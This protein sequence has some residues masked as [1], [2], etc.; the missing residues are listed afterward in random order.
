MQARLV[1]VPHSPWSEKA[2][3]ALDHHGIDYVL[4]PYQPILGE[5]ALRLKLKKRSGKVTVPVLL[6]ERGPVTDSFDIAMFA[7]RHGHGA[8]LFR[9]GDKP[10]IDHWN[11]VSERAM[12]AGRGLHLH[13]VRADPEALREALPG[14]FPATLKRPLATVARV[15]YRIIERKYQIDSDP[16]RQRRILFDCLLELRHALADGRPYLL[17]ELSYADVVMAAAVGV[18][19]PPESPAVTIGPATRRTWTDVELSSDFTDLV[20][21]R[22]Q[23]YQRHRF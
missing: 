16:M 6:T 23:L 8:P 18:I 10:A 1:A 4:D 21:W 9:R 13:R 15:G 17:G 14:V 19:Q 20:A 3:W 2:R 22:D 5:P 7:E 12:A 11:Q